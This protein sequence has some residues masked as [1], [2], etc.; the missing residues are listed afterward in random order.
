MRI[1]VPREIKNH[2]YRVGLTPSSVAELCGHGHAVWVESQAGAAIGFG[3]ADYAAAG[4]R[5]VADA[6][7]V[8][9]A[10]ELIVKVKE[11]LAAERAADGADCCLDKSHN[12]YLTVLKNFWNC[13]CFYFTG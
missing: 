1:G 3:D 11:P 6:A 7:E 8:F 4:A 2:E 13:S 10:A 12:C 9:A 5:V